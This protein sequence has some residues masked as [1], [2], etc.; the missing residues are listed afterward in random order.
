MTD[1]LNEADELV[2]KRGRKVTLSFASKEEREAFEQAARKWDTL[3]NLCADMGIDRAKVDAFTVAHIIRLALDAKHADD[4][5]RYD[6]GLPQDD[7]AGE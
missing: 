7:E 4:A 6:A 1:R 2:A 5:T 3:E